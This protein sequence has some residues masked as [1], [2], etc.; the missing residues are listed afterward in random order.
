MNVVVNIP[1]IANA[2]P[3]RTIPVGALSNLDGTGSYDPDGSGI[4]YLWAKVSGPYP[5]TFSNERTATPTIGY[6]SAGVITFELTVTDY[7]GFTHKDTVNITFNLR[8]VAKAGQDQTVK[9]NSPVTLDGSASSDSDGT[10]AGY[11][12]QQ[13][14]GS[15]RGP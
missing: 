5:N 15:A 11:L 6:G 2:G 14:K 3:D 13:T 9:R 10:I 12:W 1:P 7:W 4:S 8:P